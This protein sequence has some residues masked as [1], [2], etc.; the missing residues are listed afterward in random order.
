MENKY[1]HIEQ[2]TDIENDLN[3]LYIDEILEIRKISRLNKNWKLS[4]ILRNYLDAKLVFAFDAPDCQEVYYLNDYSFKY[5]DRIEKLYEIKF[6]TKRK[7]VEWN[8]KA[9]IKSNNLFDAWLYTQEQKIN[10][11]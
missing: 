5:L 11:K 4:D 9:E 2:S 1:K 8:I 10:D 7:F 6:S 3:L